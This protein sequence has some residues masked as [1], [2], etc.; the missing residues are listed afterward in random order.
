MKPSPNDMQHLN[1]YNEYQDIAEVYFAYQKIHNFIE[2]P[3][4][5]L[6]GDAYLHQ[7]LNAARFIIS[8]QN[9]SLY[10]VNM[11]YVYYALGKVAK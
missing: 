3:F 7:I 6:S 5:P 10:G 9:R 8:K 2:E 1:T 4:Q 11:S